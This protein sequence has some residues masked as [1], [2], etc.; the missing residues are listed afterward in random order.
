MRIPRFSVFLAALALPLA[1]AAC[2]DDNVT[3]TNQSLAR[4]TVDAPN[5]AT[6]G[7]SFGVQVRA[8]NVGLAG[9]HN[10]HITVTL[11]VPLTVVSVSAPSGTTATFSNGAAGGRVEW[12]FG[13]LDSNSEAK[14]DITVIGVLAPT[15][16][17]KRLTVVATMTADG[18]KPGDAVA[19]DDVTLMP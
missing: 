5:T 14:L 2:H 9:I 12:D 3:A 11:P 13:T 7:T 17:S 18:I 16:P 8:L 10:S 6:S 19:Q 4:L 15:D 1:F